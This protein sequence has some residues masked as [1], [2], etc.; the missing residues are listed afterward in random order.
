MLCFELRYADKSLTDGGK[1]VEV[2]P[3][4]NSKCK[5]HLYEVSH[6]GLPRV[7][8]KSDYIRGF[9]VTISYFRIGTYLLR[10]QKSVFLPYVDN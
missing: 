3:T 5:I 7:S 6:R 4:Q 9:F 8:M 2:K 10:S 1:N